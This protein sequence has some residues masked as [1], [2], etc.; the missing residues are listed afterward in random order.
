MQ[1]NLRQ[2]ALFGQYYGGLH[3]D[4]HYSV[5]H[6]TIT[7]AQYR[8]TLSTAFVPSLH[9]FKFRMAAFGIDILRANNIADY[10]FDSFYSAF[11]RCFLFELILLI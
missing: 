5:A 3:I 9:A 1:T 7:A 6:S 10:L 8:R 2:V 4:F 11:S